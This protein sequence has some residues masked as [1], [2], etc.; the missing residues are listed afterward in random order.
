MAARSKAWV[1]GRSLA[2]IA[3]SNIANL[4]DVCLMRLL[5]VVM[6]RSLRRADPKSRRVLPR[7]RVSGEYDR[8]ASIMW[9]P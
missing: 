3:G 8:E 9:K 4:K 7:A 2:E 6:Y 5:C 1:W